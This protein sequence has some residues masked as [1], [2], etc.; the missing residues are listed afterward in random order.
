[1]SH[2]NMSKKKKIMFVITK[3]NFGGAQ[4]Y[5]YDLATH[6]SNEQYDV[7]VMHGTAGTALDT[8]GTLA[9]ML[10]KA[11]IRTIHV[12]TLGRDIST[13]HDLETFKTLIHVFKKE[14]PD[15]VHLNSSKIGG[16]GALAARIARVPHVVFT[17]HGW[18]FREQRNIFAR[19]IIWIASLMTVALSHITICVSE[20]DYRA[21][22]NIP[23]IGRKLVRIHNGINL[24]M[25]FNSGERIRSAFPPGAHIIGTIGELTKNKNQI[26]L[27]EDA[28][29]NPNMCVAIVGEGELRDMLEKRIQEYGLSERVKLFGFV[30]AMEV[31]KGFDEFALPSLKEGM[32]YVLLEAKLAGLPITARRV[33]GTGEVIDGAIGDFSLERMVR[34]TEAVYTS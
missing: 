13:T 11:G 19:T 17:A 24:S 26:S 30:P 14:Q 10:A 18:P 28:R 31:I 33:G 27:V 16:L 6:L 7:L 12:P 5:V 23:L 1:M 15:V 29:K 25:Q 22:K 20:S 3:S 32:P 34:D 8:P 9:D 2:H 4:R 21:M